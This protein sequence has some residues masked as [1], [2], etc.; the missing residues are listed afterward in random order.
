MPCNRWGAIPAG[1]RYLIRDRDPFYTDKFD[2]ILKAAGVKPMRLPTR[3]PDLN[4]YAERFVRSI[5]EE[6]LNQLTFP[7]KSNCVTSCPSVSNTIITGGFTKASIESSSRSTKRTT[8]TSFASSD[9]AD[10]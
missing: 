5:K 9:W 7:L 10:C 4:A 1:K 2:G 6:R 3:S 8:A